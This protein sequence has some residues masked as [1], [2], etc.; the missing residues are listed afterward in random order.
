VSRATLC[1]KRLIQCVLNLFA[2]E[3]LESNGAG[4]SIVTNR[5]TDKDSASELFPNRELLG[6]GTHIVY[7]FLKVAISTE[8]LIERVD[9]A[10][11]PLNPLNVD[12]HISPNVELIRGYA[13]GSVDWFGILFA[14]NSF[15]RVRSHHGLEYSIKAYE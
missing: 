15:I 3:V 2:G 9:F 11:W 7:H 5:V 12:R 4:I 10:G 13:V 6:H 14:V 1:C 8:A